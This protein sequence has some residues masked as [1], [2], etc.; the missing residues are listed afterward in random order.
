MHVDEHVCVYS[1]TDCLVTNIIQAIDRCEETANRM[2]VLESK[3]ALLNL[4][5]RKSVE[6]HVGD[7]GHRISTRMDVS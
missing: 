5:S 7:Q 2:Q 6:D 3:V 1:Q 4:S